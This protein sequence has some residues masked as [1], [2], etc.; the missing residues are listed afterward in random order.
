MAQQLSRESATALYLHEH[1]ERTGYIYIEQN[2]EWGLDPWVMITGTDRY[3][4]SGQIILEY[5]RT[6]ERIVPPDFKI[7]LD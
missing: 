6:G 4:E 5:G 1:P 7:Y 3:I 2:A